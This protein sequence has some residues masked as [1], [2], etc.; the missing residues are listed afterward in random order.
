MNVYSLSDTLIQQR[1]GEKLKK[2]RLR[3]NI[4]QANLANDAQ[5]SLSSV[6]KIEKGQI[7][8]FECFMRILRVLGEFDVFQPLVEDEDM[9]PNEYFEFINS[10]KKKERQRAVSVKKNNGNDNEYS[11]W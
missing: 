1:I 7:G 4:T 3:Q 5:V 2:L 8:S 11:E 6:K 9:S 10:A